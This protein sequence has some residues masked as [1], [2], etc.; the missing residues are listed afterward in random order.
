MKDWRVDL[1]FSG[2][3][4]LI[5]FAIVFIKSYS[6][7]ILP[8]NNIKLN[9][10]IINLKWDPVKFATHYD[11][12]IYKNKV[13]IKNTYIP[14]INDKYF[15]CYFEKEVIIVYKTKETKLDIDFSNYESFKTIKYKTG[16]YNTEIQLLEYVDGNYGI[17]IKA[18]LLFL[19]I[20]IYS[21]EHINK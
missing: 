4:F 10:N 20:K 16:F 17:D 11:V 12:S 14:Q 9:N 19:P 8:L 15:F 7:E 6:P 3:I 21:N 5:L 2:I 13:S 1:L 18:Y